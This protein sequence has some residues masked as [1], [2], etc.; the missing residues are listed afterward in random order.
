M[1]NKPNTPEQ[2][3][4]VPY[5]GKFKIKLEDLVKVTIKTLFLPTNP[6]NLTSPPPFFSQKLICSC[7]LFLIYSINNKTKL[8]LTHTN[9]YKFPKKNNTFIPKTNQ[10][11]LSSKICINSFQFSDRFCWSRA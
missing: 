3:A 5:N 1:S 11:K 7:Y 9:E 4:P 2:E 10:I 8:T 6:P